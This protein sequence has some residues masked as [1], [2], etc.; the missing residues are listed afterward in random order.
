VATKQKNAKN[1][2]TTDEQESTA[3]PEAREDGT[4]KLSWSFYGQENTEFVVKRPQT[5]ADCLDATFGGRTAP[6]AASEKAIV[7]AFFG[8]YCVLARRDSDE[9]GLWGTE[10]KP[11]QPAIEEVRAHYNAF[12]A[13]ESKGARKGKG[14]VAPVSKKSLEGLSAE[15]KLARLESMGML[16]E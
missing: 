11:R 14:K 2:K 12:T 7:D 16:V 15:E 8:Q 13:S 6:M 9:A 4:R 10:D 1:A 5:I 3:T